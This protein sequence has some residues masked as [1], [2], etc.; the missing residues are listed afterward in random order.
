MSDLKR[1]YTRK[2]L[3]D[4]VWSTPIVKLAEQFDLSDRGLAKTC[5]RHQIPVPGRG[6][7]ARVEAGQPVTKTPLRKMYTP[8]LET[9]HIGASK[10]TVN[11][12]VAFAIEAATSAVQQAKVSRADN[13]P[14]GKLTRQ[15]PI[16]APPTAMSSPPARPELEPVRKP[17]SAIAGLVGDL[18]SA[19][20]DKDGEIKVSGVRINRSCLTRSIAVLHHLA[21][22]LDARGIS[23]TC[24]SE[25]IMASIGV[26]RVR[27][28]LTEEYRRQKHEPTPTE[29]KK[30]Q[31]FER[32]RELA[33]RRGE[34]LWGERFW[35]EFDYVY[36]GKLTFE[37]HNWAEG[38][39][40][41]WS[42]GKHQSLE[43]M[44]ESMADGVLFH[45]VFD[46]ARRE[47]REEQE[48]QRQHLAHRRKLQELRKVREDDRLTF[49]KQLA[50]YQREAADLSAT[51]RAASSNYDSSPPEYKR[52]IDWARKR[53]KFI[54]DQNDVATLARNLQ[55]AK[56]FPEVDELHD[57]EGEPP[58]S[59]SLLP[60]FLSR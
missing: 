25:N 31:D 47:E 15:F 2:E 35:P 60:G 45:L 1:T 59:G 46:K 55:A 37:I 30:E 21:V 24:T 26:D 32:K 28:D 4:M 11:P 40:K 58:S 53:L 34:W 18:K 49:L 41:K 38:A 12:Y 42:D 48:W 29:L 50:E 52:M 44:L 3:Y 16:A 10:V 5:Q 56:L 9:V 17:H 54:A 23:L 39:R 36:T 33:R 27:F 51:I 43:T 8:E 57:P 19:K 20:A 13:K 22:E 14:N 7:W 6:Y